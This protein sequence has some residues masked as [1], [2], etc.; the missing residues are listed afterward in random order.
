MNAS[1]FSRSTSVF[2]K[3][4]YWDMFH[5]KNTYLYL[6]VYLVIMPRYCLCLR[7]ILVSAEISISNFGTFAILFIIFYMIVNLSSFLISSCVFQTIPCIIY[8]TWL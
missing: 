4:F 7:L 6:F 8:I 1:T 2:G 3:Q 5:E